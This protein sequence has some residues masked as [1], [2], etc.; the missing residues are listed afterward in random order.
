MKPTKATGIIV[1]ENGD[2]L[3]GYGFGGRNGENGRSL[4]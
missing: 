2:I 4:F 3:Y 1:F